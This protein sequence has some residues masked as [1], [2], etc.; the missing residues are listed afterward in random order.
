MIDAGIVAL[1][2]Y[3]TDYQE[4]SSAELVRRA[5]LAMVLA[6]SQGSE[7]NTETS[8]AIDR[9]ASSANTSGVEKSP[10]NCGPSFAITQYSPRPFGTGQLLGSNDWGRN[11]TVIP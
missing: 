10:A 2:D 4:L 11:W 8:E 5:F 9:L 1:A 3:G 7:T 6:Q